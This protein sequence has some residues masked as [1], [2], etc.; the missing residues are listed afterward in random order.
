MNV[1]VT[2]YDEKWPSM[3][4]EEARAL[5]AVFADECIDIHHIGS[6]SVPGL[7]AK[8]IIDIMPVVK[9]IEKAES[10]REEMIQLG[11]EPLGEAGISGRRYYRKGGKHRT[12]HVHMFQFDHDE[13]IERHIA[14]RDY[15][16]AHRE[17]AE[18]Y[19]CL[20]ARLAKQFPYDIEAYMDGKDKFVKQLEQDALHW[21][22]ND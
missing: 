14:F 6:T 13:E 12:H 4:E 2:V 8:P 11:Y 19:G 21:K 22:A 16:R 1:V 15:L 17:Q 5:K 20:K 9:N 10:F 18:K 3:F 7:L